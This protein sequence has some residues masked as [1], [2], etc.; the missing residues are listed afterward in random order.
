MNVISQSES[1][2]EGSL[3][4]MF[5]KIAFFPP[6][7]CITVIMRFSVRMSPN[8][9]EA[10]TELVVTVATS[11]SYPVA[12]TILQRLDKALLY[13]V[14]IPNV[15]DY[16][17]PWYILQYVGN[18]KWFKHTFTHIHMQVTSR[19]TPCDWLPASGYPSVWT[20]WFLSPVSCE[21]HCFLWCD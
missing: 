14:A 11:M 4:N 5:L 21:D 2:P 13:V 15:R 12:F 1:Q 20:S 3:K 16:V 6:C 9:I 10:E 17:R 7:Y 18:N 8:F 19:Q